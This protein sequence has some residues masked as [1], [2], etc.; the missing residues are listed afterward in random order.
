MN[1]LAALI[2]SAASISAC[3][4]RGVPS[5]VRLRLEY[6]EGDTL[7]YEYHTEGTVTMPDTSEQSGWRSQPYQRNLIV[8][9]CCPLGI[10]NDIVPSLRLKLKAV[11]LTSL[12]SSRTRTGLFPT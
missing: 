1:R 12:S 3:G 11:A 4:E 2:L 9:L 8:K 7:L 10:T 6:E 5:E